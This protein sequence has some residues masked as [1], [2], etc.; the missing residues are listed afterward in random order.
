MGVTRDR[1]KLF[2]DKQNI[3][4][5]EF[6]NKTELSNAYVSTLGDAP[7]QSTIDKIKKAY[8]ELNITWLL[9]GEGAMLLSDNPPDNKTQVKKELYHLVD[10]LLSLQEIKKRLSALEEKVELLVSSSTM[11]AHAKGK[12]SKQGERTAGQLKGREPF[13]KP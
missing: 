1:L 5:P 9:T 4:E 7:R 10:E 3:S 2:L 8:P 11:T 13:D 6:Q 12:E